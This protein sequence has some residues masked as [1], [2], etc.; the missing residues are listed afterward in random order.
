MEVDRLRTI[1]DRGGN[2][3]ETQRSVSAN[4][5]KNDTII[6]LY[7]DNQNLLQTLQETNKEF[8]SKW[9]YMVNQFKKVKDIALKYKKRVK[10]AENEIMMMKAR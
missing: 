4:K 8:E 5:D 7:Q 1:T 2:G 10:K 6:T 9:D 3:N